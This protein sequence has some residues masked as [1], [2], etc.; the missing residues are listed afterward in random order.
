MPHQNV[1]RGIVVRGHAQVTALAVKPRLD[2]AVGGR[3]VA[4]VMAGLAGVPRVHGHKLPTF[5]L[6]A[7]GQLAPIAGQDAAV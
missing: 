5:V 3:D 4:A 7:W 6:Q 1:E 2:R